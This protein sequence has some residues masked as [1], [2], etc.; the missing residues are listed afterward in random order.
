MVG[1]GRGVIF[2]QPT[3]ARLALACVAPPLHHHQPHSGL[4]CAPARAVTACVALANI[5]RSSLGPVGLDKMLVRWGTRGWRARARARARML[6][7]VF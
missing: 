1:A 5:V 2:R 4:F 3:H 6:V 7:V